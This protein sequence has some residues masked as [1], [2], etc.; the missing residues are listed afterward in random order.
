MTDSTAIFPSAFPAPSL[1]CI[2]SPISSRWIAVHFSTPPNRHVTPF[3]ELFQQDPKRGVNTCDE[4]KS[5]LRT[6][7]VNALIFYVYRIPTTQ[8]SQQLGSV[9]GAECIELTGKP[10]KHGHGVARKLGYKKIHRNDWLLGEIRGIEIVSDTRKYATQ[11]EEFVVKRYRACHRSETLRFPFNTALL[12]AHSAS[13]I[14]R[15]AAGRNGY[16]HSGNR[17]DCGE[18]P[19]SDTCPICP[20]SPVRCQRTNVDRHNSSRFLSPI[21]P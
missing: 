16:K 7:I 19:D 8:N 5:L 6:V 11:R 18:D 13:L 20:I 10:C 15:C 2:S 4:P 3:P 1:L 17:G 12:V 9:L 21:L 14:D